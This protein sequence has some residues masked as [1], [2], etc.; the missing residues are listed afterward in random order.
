MGRSERSSARCDKLRSSGGLKNLNSE[1]KEDA[2]KVVRGEGKK[3]DEREFKVRERG[4][5]RLT[6][7][8]SRRANRAEMAEVEKKT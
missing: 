3:K 6:P 5:T 4:K 1:R 8:S 2:S 7:P